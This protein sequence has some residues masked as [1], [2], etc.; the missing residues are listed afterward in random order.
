MNQA[1][2]KLH[3]LHRLYTSKNMRSPSSSFGGFRPS[4]PDSTRYLEERLPVQ[5][6]VLPNAS[7]RYVTRFARERL[8]M[9]GSRQSCDC[10]R[11]VP[12]LNNLSRCDKLI[13][14]VWCLLCGRK[15]DKID[16]WQ[17]LQFFLS[18]RANPSSVSAQVSQRNQCTN[19]RQNNHFEDQTIT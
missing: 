8:C 3:K 15:T 11:S 17:I 14:D 7:S 6:F 1:Q 13:C 18:T 9:N 4:L 16:R 12:A 19:P 2:G 10:P 5:W